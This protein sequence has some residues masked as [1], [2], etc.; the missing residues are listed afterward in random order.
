ML[1]DLLRALTAALLLGLLPGW[2]WARALCPD[3]DSTALRL[4]YSTALSLA[5]VPAVSLALV[6]MLRSGVTLFVAV[7]SAAVV[8]GA[9]FAAYRWFGTAGT[10]GEPLAPRP[11]F[12][13]GLPV[14]AWLVFSGVLMLLA[15]PGPVPVLLVKTKS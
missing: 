15:S 5:L 6:R 12:S 2:F 11:D 13:P 7:F 3:T 4:V 9:G 1:L 14:S 8:F 10:T